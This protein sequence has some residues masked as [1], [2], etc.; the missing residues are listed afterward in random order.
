MQRIEL[1]ENAE[2]N[3]VKDLNAVGINNTMYWA[4]QKSKERQTED[5]DFNDTIWEKDIEEIVK[6]CRRERIPMFTI[7]STF[8]GLT[9]TIWKLVELG[10]KVE[11]MKM[12]PLG[13]MDY[14]ITT[15]E[16]KS[17]MA[18]AFIIKVWR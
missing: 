7:S 18:P 11:G 10:C 13:Y 4:Y 12:V 5:L 3:K 8:C 9:K 15:G 6:T 1:F 16:K 2:R 17:A 14:D